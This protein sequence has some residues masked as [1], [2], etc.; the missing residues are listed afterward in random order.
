LPENCHNINF[1]TKAEGW[2]DIVRARE[3]TNQKMIEFYERVYD[4][5]KPKSAD[6]D[7][8]QFILELVRNTQPGTVQPDYN[9]IQSKIK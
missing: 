3:A 4:D 7:I 8:K 9:A 6:G 5:I 2:R 1:V